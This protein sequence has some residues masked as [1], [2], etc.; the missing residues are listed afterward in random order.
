MQVIRW[1]ADSVS[2]V[3][4]RLSVKA[5]LLCKR[6]VCFVVV[7]FYFR[8]QRR[9]KRSTDRF[10]AATNS[11]PQ[12]DSMVRAAPAKDVHDGQ[13]WFTAVFTDMFQMLVIVSR[14]WVSRRIGGLLRFGIFIE[15][16]HHSWLP[17]V[18]SGERGGRGRG[19]DRWSAACMACVDG[20]TLGFHGA[21]YAFLHIWFTSCSRIITSFCVFLDVEHGS[22]F[23][24]L[25][26]EF[27]N[28][29]PRSGRAGTQASPCR[30]ANTEDHPEVHFSTCIRFRFLEALTF[31]C[32]EVEIPCAKAPHGSPCWCHSCF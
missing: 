9:D 30:I 31:D 8:G 18:T 24:K 20:K 3:G 6:Q 17:S 29:S 16:T 4:K 25:L 22:V 28:P 15:V 19:E 23:R 2:A 12:G 1:I 7:I 21:F 14:F 10:S 27:W 32:I 13:Q 26:Q 11:A 5:L